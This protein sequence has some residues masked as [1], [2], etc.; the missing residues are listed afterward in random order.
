[1]RRGFGQL[2]R[3]PDK[4]EAA[5][6]GTGLVQEIADVVELRVGTAEPVLD[7]AEI[8]D[9]MAGLG[10]RNAHVPAAAFADAPGKRRHS[11]ERHEIAGGMVEHL[12][13]QRVRLVAAGRLRLGMIEAARGLHQGIEAAPAA[14]GA[15]VAV[16]R[17]RDID[18]AGP[19]LRGVFR[20]EAEL[21]EA[22][23]PVALDEH[24]GAAQQ[25]G[26][27]VAPGRIAQ[28]DVRRQFSSAGVDDELLDRGQVRGGDEQ[29]LGAMG[30][31]RA[32]GDRAGDDAGQ[33]EHPH[34]G[35]RSRPGRQRLGVRIADPLDREH[36]QGRDRAA[37]GMR[38]PFGKRAHRGHDQPGL[39][40]RRFQIFRA[41]VLQRLLD[42]IAVVG[43]AQQFQHAVAVMREIGVQAYPTPV[44]AAVGAGDLV[45]EIRQGLGGD[46]QIALAA[47]LDRCVAHVER[48][49]L[50]FVGPQPPQLGRGERGCR[51]ARLRGG[52][53]RKRGRQ[54][55]IRAGELDVFERGRIPAERAPERRQRLG[56]RGRSDAVG[57]RERGHETPRLMASAPAIRMTKKTENA[58]ALT[59]SLSFLPNTSTANGR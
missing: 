25:G 44:A 54:H 46:A 13:G 34:A 5:E 39:G 36:R 32:P 20:T 9:P 42:R 29:H 45:P 3:V 18:D 30:G 17:E 50:A 56:G 24:V 51:D 48:D 6:A 27:R 35:K 4:G 21:G 37:L 11:P 23:R 2:R 19:D 7:P 52:A 8:A 1:M 57:A 58:V 15:L 10:E 55:R 33:I 47:A 41:P 49:A 28:I 31:E 43:A 59:S 53:D 14:P 12:H 38:V 16:S 40:R 22:A 26:E